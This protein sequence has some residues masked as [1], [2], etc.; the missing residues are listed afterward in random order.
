MCGGGAAPVD[1]VTARVSAFTWQLVASGQLSVMSSAP[2]FR[3]TGTAAVSHVSQSAVAG[4]D[5]VRLAPLAETV[6]VRV[7]CAPSPP[8]PL[9]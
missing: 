4:S 9:A 8:V 3:V 1:V 5:S 6:A 2:A 7:R